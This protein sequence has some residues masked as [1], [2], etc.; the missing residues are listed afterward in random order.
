MH[1]CERL[2]PRG[3]LPDLLQGPLSS[4]EPSGVPACSAVLSEISAQSRTDPV[5]SSFWV[6]RTGQ[7]Y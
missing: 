6:A 3:R 2:R 7:C 4:A 1:A 5:L